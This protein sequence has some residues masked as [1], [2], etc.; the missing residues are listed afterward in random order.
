MPFDPTKPAFGS[1]D[2]SAEMRAQ[3][4]GL[5]DLMDAIPAGPPGPQ[6]DPGPQ[7]TQ[8]PPGPSVAAA[9]VDG[10]STL[11]PGDAATVSTSFDGSNVHF[12]FGIPRGNDGNQGPQGN[13]GNDGAPGPQGPQG[14]MGD[15]STAALAAAIA[16][17][18]NNT[19]AI[20]TLDT[21]FADP[22]SEALRQAF[23]AL[24]MALRR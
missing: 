1:P 22:D 17:T 13:T 15:V 24:V 18:S 5:K 7:G 16:G 8:G 12:T 11:N 6:G 20:A 14:P 3:F 21:P 19:N 2:S 4:N 23:N 9:V 10:V